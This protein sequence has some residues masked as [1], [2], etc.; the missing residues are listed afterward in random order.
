M[1]A[2][3]FLTTHGLV[4]TYIG[5]HPERT[6]L[7]IAQA[8]GVTERAVRQIIADLHAA[9]YVAPDKIGRRNRYRI[10]PALPLRGL[11][12]RAVTV[13]ELLELLW[14]DDETA[15]DSVARG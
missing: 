6:G 7:E 11:G 9:G 5:R 1:A 10:D 14:G 3:T 13:G 2:W 4:L 12:E 8:V 15:P